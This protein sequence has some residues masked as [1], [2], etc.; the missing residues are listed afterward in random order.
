MPSDAVSGGTAGQVSCLVDREARAS[1]R[2]VV[3]QIGETVRSSNVALI[4]K[5][6]ANPAS[7]MERILTGQAP[8]CLIFVRCRCRYLVYV[9]TASGWMRRDIRVTLYRR[10]MDDA[11]RLR[12]PVLG[13][14]GP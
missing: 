4:M 13:V 5:Q 2:P 10:F 9:E 1:P 7:V 11:P 6:F 12:R 3:P 8:V 14:A